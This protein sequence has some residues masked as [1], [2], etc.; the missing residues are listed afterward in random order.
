MVTKNLLN[1][2]VKKYRKKLCSQI[3][4]GKM[5]MRAICSKFKKHDFSILSLGEV[6]QNGHFK[7]VQKPFTAIRP[8][9]LFCITTVC[10]LI[11]S[12]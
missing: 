12:Y 10:Q 7:N 6:W 1:D 3:I 4:S 8:D 11:P 2:S 9:R 5:K